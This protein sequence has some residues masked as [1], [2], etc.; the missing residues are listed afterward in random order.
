MKSKLNRADI[1]SRGLR[2]SE[3]IDSDLWF[4]GPSIILLDDVPYNRFS[5]KNLVFKNDTVLVN[6]STDSNNDFKSN[7]VDLKFMNIEKYCTYSKI[8]RVI[9]YVLRFI[10]TLQGRSKKTNTNLSKFITKQES[11]LAEHLWR[12]HI[13]KDVFTDRQYEQLKHDLGFI[14]IDGVIR[15][16]GR[17]G[18][19]SLSFNTKHPLFL[20]KCYFTKLV[21]LYYHQIVLHNGAKEMLNEIRTKFWV[22]KTTNFIQ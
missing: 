11:V 4:K 3:L 19:S 20:P 10:N 6:T 14:V 17:L 15:C 18:N 8:L 21:T 13:Q 5:L 2:F 7:P 1:L 22:P 12:M 9:A 16:K